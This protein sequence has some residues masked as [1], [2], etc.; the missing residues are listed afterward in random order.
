[1]KQVSFILLAVLLGLGAL[2]LAAQEKRSA[3]VV[4]DVD[5]KKWDLGQ[6]GVVTMVLYTSQAN[7]DKSRAAGRVFDSLRGQPGFRMVALIDLRETLA[8]WAPGYTQRRILKNLDEET[9]RLKPF[10]AGNGSKIDP[11][12]EV[13]AVTDF[14]GEVCNQLGWTTVSKGVRFIIFDKDGNEIVRVDGTFDEKAVLAK[15]NAAMKA[16]PATPKTPAP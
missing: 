8:D 4:T 9:I 6:T 14:K 1:M 12:K 3:V 5:G 10:Y 15:T 16:S 2:P 7:Q 11:R 13:G